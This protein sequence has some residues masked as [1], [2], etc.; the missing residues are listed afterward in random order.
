[1]ID[2]DQSNLS[3]LTHEE[4]QL[5]HIEAVRAFESLRNESYQDQI[6][7]YKN[8]RKNEVLGM[9]D[10]IVAGKR[11]KL[12]SKECNKRYRIYRDA[13]KRDNYGFIFKLDT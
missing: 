8:L 9:V 5:K 2:A 1:M 6:K 13:S 7:L 10:K 11:R 12:Q 4:R 3:N